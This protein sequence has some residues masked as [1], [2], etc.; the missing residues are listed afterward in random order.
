VDIQEFREVVEEAR[1]TKPKLFLMSSPDAPARDEQI[2]M[3]EE[4]LGMGLPLAYSQF[5]REFGGGDFGLVNIY[6]AADDS[7]WYIPMRAE[8]A[9]AQGL[10]KELLP[11]SD[12]ATGGFYVFRVDAGVADDRVLY[13]DHD[14]S[15]AEPTE[16]ADALEYLRRFAFEPA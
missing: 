13:W 16:F 6:S 10:P 5:L 2:A 4:Q 1:R 15:S 7:D 8:E 12:D 14:A 11:F 3:V 9:W